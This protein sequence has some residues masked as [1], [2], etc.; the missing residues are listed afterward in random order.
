MFDS[1]EIE[2]RRI[3]LSIIA[4]KHVSRSGVDFRSR[5]PVRLI[6]F[7]PP[8]STVISEASRVVVWPTSW[9]GGFV[10]LFWA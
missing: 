9:R 5:D 1:E 8:R 6:F 2:D 7:T 3:H 10:L 4:A